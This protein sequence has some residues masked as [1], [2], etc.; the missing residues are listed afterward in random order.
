MAKFVAVL[1][2]EPG[3]R[4]ALFDAGAVAVLTW[5]ELPACTE[6]D[7]AV[8]VLWDPSAEESDPDRFGADLAAALAILEA[9]PEVVAVTTRP[10]SD[11]LKL[12]DGAGTLT[13]TADR[14]G[15]RLVL[16]PIA[17][18]LGPLRTLASQLPA[19]P[20]PGAAP[21]PVAVLTALAARGLPLI[22]AT[23]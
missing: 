3:G 2:G 9:R 13:G 18:R 7:D 23:P 15:H 14:E 5:S 11:T 8:A 17:T 16:T 20:A 21:T 19:G 10:V 1:P 6:P 22:P 4:D 12:V